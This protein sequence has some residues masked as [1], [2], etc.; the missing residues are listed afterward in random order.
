MG[1]VPLKAK[2]AMKSMPFQPTSD[3]RASS[4]WKSKQ[5][6]WTMSGLRAIGAPMV[7]IAK[8]LGWKHQ[9]L[10]KTYNL[11]SS[12]FSYLIDTKCFHT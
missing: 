5:R 11:V 4:T 10:G 3:A 12:M 9:Q 2:A 8:F 6:E 7:G 1:K